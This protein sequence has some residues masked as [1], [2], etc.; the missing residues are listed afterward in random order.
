METPQKP[1]FSFL[2]ALTSHTPYE[3]D[4]EDQTLDLSGYKVPMLRRYYQ[5]IHYVDTD[6]GKM[7]DE[8]KRKNLWNQSLIIFYGNH[9]SV[10]YQP[11]LTGFRDGSFRYKEYYYETDFTKV[12]SR[13]TFYNLS[14][15][16]KVEM[17]F[18][19]NQMKDVRKQLKLLDKIIE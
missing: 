11:N 2:V 18:C 13:G 1:F 4:K 14:P 5:N 19:R 8:L 9:S 16:K 12:S 15:K 17:K 3:I 10:D 7:I 6:V